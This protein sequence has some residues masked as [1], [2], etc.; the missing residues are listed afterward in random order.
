MKRWHLI[1]LVL[2]PLFAM[3]LGSISCATRPLPKWEQTRT[4]M[5]TFVTVTVYTNEETAET[6][7][8]AAFERM[9]EIES[10]ASI[11]NEESGLSRLNRDGYLADP[12]PDLAT[13]ISL[14]K[15]YGWVS[16]GRFDVTI[17]PLLELW[18]EGLWRESAAVQQQRIGE[19]LEMVGWERIGTTEN[20]ISLEEGMS[21]NL[22][23][24]AKGYAA[25]EA[26]EVLQEMGIEH[27]LV[28]AGGDMTTL[29]TKPNGEPWVVALANPDDTDESLIILHLKGQAVATSG[30][31]ERYFD[32]ERGAHHIIDPLSGYS[33]QGVISATVIAPDATQADALATTVFVMGAEDGVA[34]V[35]TIPSVECLIVSEERELY[36]SSGL[37]A[38][39]E[40][41]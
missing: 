39:M 10:E 5:G 36:P 27:A 17:Q 16:G 9:E 18:E 20:G 23:G 8:E 28:N 14:S 21:I 35:E 3:T 29:G 34:L 15:H 31:Y 26:L 38:F 13:L 41:N 12:S 1:A 33:A 4:L 22:G 32:P 30:N 6:A 19:A 37:D 40:L 7:I 24:I 11:Y 25:D 2:V